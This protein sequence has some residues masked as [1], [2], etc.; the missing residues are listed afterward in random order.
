M[1]RRLIGALLALGCVQACGESTSNAPHQ[2]GA[3]TGSGAGRAG[4]FSS[5]GTDSTSQAG[6]ATSGSTQSSAGAAGVGGST[7][8]GG[9][10]NASG[11]GGRAGSSSESGATSGEGG[12]AGQAGQT[13]EPMTDPR[14]GCKD[15]PLITLSAIRPVKGAGP[16]GTATFELD[17]TNGTAQFTSYN[18][19][20]FGCTGDAVEGATDLLNTFGTSPGDTDTVQ[21]NVKFKAGATHGSVAHC[22]ARGMILGK[23][24]KDCANAQTRSIDVTVE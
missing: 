18:S 5:G 11:S 14:P 19:V 2:A 12:D 16:G 9:T 13:G 24:P 21:L 17:V 4:A 1:S 6:Q 23:S 20:T 22:T 3:G 8:H 10:G 7:S 15:V